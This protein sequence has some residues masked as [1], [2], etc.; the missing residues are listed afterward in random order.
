M[1]L[2]LQIISLDFYKQYK[3]MSHTLSN[4]ISSQKA[5]VAKEMYILIQTM[6]GQGLKREQTFL[7]ILS[8]AYTCSIHYDPGSY[9]V[10][11]NP[12]PTP[13]LFVN[14]KHIS[15]FGVC[16][17]FLISLKKACLFFLKSITGSYSSLVYTPDQ[18]IQ[19]CHRQGYKL[20][21]PFWQRQLL[22]D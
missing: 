15:N 2:A 20:N 9:L 22:E 6:E 7:S 18:N 1:W 21:Y 14:W 12:H 17:F 19:Q 11:P 16:F 10:M 5:V 13:S 4:M 8:N 3:E